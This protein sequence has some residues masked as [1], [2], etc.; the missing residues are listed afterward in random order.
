MSARRRPPDR[1]A[2]TPTMQVMSMLRVHDLQNALVDEDAA[3]GLDPDLLA[4]PFAHIVVDEAQELTDAEWQML[5]LRCPSA[6]LHHR[7]GSG[8]GAARVR[9]V[10]AGTPPADR[11]GPDQP[12]HADHQLPHAGGGH[13]GGRA[14][15]PGRAPGRQRADV[16][17]A[18]AASPSSTDPDRTWT[19][20]STT[21]LAENHEGIACVIGD[22]TFRATSRV[23]SLTPELSKG[24]EFDLVVL[25]DPD[26]FGHGI[27]GAVDRYVAMTRA[28]QQLGD[29]HQRLITETVAAHSPRP[30]SGA[31]S[32][33]RFVA[34]RRRR[35]RTPRTVCGPTRRGP[36]SLLSSRRASR[37]MGCATP[38]MRCRLS[39]TAETQ[40]HLDY[41]ITSSAVASRAGSRRGSA[42]AR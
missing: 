34:R 14:G 6:Q 1:D 2:T 17:S 41:S 42:P 27:E 25:I 38:G 30:R 16:R 40:Q 32:A 37:R 26:T 4:G 20:S 24:L 15:D 21:W 8:P 13:G 3:G 7:R 39:P 10:L 28:T 31:G 35:P 22:P 36:A 18:A 5:L 29:P 9:G 19:R 23:R 12:G 33:T 11:A